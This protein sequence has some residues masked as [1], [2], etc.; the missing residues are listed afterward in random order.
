LDLVE[1][2]FFSAAN[3]FATVLKQDG[4]I[5]EIAAQL[6]AAERLNEGKDLV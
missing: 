2:Q 6:I 3:N 1:L 4:K 5:A